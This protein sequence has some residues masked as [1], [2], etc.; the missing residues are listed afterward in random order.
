MSCNQFDRAYVLNMLSEAF[1]IMCHDYAFKYTDTEEDLRAIV[2]RFMRGKLDVDPSWR[3]F[4]SY[5]TYLTPKGRAVKPDLT[6]TRSKSK[7]GPVSVEI[8]VEMKN[9]PSVKGVQTDINKLIDLRDAFHS[10]APDIIFIAILKKKCKLED[11]KKKLK[12]PINSVDHP[13]I[14]ID[15]HDDLYKGPWDYKK[16]TD[17]WRTKL[18]WE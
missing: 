7:D 6:F 3:I 12:L 10:D 15:G 17:P 13:Y 1:V 8:F 2:Y 11:F 5:K 4:L 16:N 9:W 18:R 14:L